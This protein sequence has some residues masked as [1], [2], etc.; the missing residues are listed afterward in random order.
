MTLWPKGHKLL[1]KYFLVDFFFRASLYDTCRLSLCKRLCD[2]RLNLIPL[3]TMVSSF[4]ERILLH[5]ISISFHFLDETW[6]EKVL[7]H[8]LTLSLQS[9]LSRISPPY[10][11]FFYGVL[12]RLYYKMVIYHCLQ[13]LRDLVG[14]KD[15]VRPYGHTVIRLLL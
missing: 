13:E 4:L 9:P 6:L 2:Q 10:E 1:Y 12:G 15:L 8:P 7:S 14:L 5:G 11:T 3:K